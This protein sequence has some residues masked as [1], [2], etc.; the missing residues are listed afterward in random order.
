MDIFK[1]N[2]PPSL[3]SDD[4]K[5]LLTM[6]NY[7]YKEFDTDSGEF[8]DYDSTIGKSI[9]LVDLIEYS[10]LGQYQGIVD[11]L[12]K[13]SPHKTF[14]KTHNREDYDTDKDF[15]NAGIPVDLRLRVGDHF[16]QIFYKNMAKIISGDKILNFDTEI[17]ICDKHV[18]TTAEDLFYNTRFF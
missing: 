5:D 14:K 10:N 2:K 11:S 1:I 13:K 6:F 3:R 12:V 7:K 16:E 4:V 17:K 9:I 15:V 18:N 8:S